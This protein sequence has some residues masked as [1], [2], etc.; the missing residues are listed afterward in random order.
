MV[1]DLEHFPL[2]MLDFRSIDP[3]QDFVPYDQVSPIRHKELYLIK[4]KEEHQWYWASQ[5]K[6]S[7]LLV[8]VQYDSMVG[9]QARC[10]YP[11]M[12]VQKSHDVLTA[13]VC[14]HAGFRNTCAGPNATMRK[15]IETR[16]V[17]ITKIRSV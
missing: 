2:A 3:M 9:S 17:V 11:G 13:T 14:P 15:S 8:F 10:K 1:E 4:P 6:R 12:P 7:E 16:S 5:Q